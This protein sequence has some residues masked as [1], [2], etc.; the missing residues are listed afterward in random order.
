[1]WLSAHALGLE[2]SPQRADLVDQNI[3]QLGAGNSHLAPPEALEVGEGRM[4][5]DLDLVLLGEAHGL[6][7]HHRVRGMEAAGDIRDRDVRHDA[8]VVAHFVEAEALAHIAVD[9]HCHRELPSQTVPWLLPNILA[10][11]AT[12][13]PVA[14]GCFTPAHL[15]G[16]AAEADPRPRPGSRG[17]RSPRSAGTIRCARGS[18]RSESGR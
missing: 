2:E 6:V 4:R 10:A 5:A 17:R 7:H 3:G 1:M 12:D 16:N 14:L 13:R 18:C 11:S 8:V 9:R 15:P